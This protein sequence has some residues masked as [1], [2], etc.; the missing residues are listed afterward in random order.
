MNTENVKL[1]H[2]AGRW[3]VLVLKRAGRATEATWLPLGG[4]PS[5]VVATRVWLAVMAQ[6]AH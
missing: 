3:E 1:R 4:C 5:Q 6:G 2:V